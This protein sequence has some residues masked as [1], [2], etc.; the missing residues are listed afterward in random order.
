MMLSCLRR[1]C[2]DILDINLVSILVAVRKAVDLSSLMM[3]T[4]TC[5]FTLHYSTLKMIVLQDISANHK[6]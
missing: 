5:V 6:S 3:D 2:G 1:V 4:M